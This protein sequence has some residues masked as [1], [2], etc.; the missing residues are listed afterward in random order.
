MPLPMLLQ[1]TGSLILSGCNFT[2][3]VA[4]FLPSIHLLN[5]SSFRLAGGVYPSCH[6]QVASKGFISPSAMIF[7]PKFNHYIECLLNC[8]TDTL[9]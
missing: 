7:S 3:C 6:R 5:P 2:D 9:K 4:G 8:C 1:P